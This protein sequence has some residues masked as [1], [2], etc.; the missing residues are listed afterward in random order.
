MRIMIDG[1][2]YE[3]T[4]VEPPKAKEWAVDVV[5]YGYESGAT[6]VCMD[7][8]GRLGRPKAV[9]A[10]F[11]FSEEGVCFNDAEAK[12]LAKAIREVARR[13]PTLDGIILENAATRLAG[14]P[15]K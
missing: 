4:K 12:G 14:P 6:Y 1:T 9:A 5:F 15:P 3:A 8:T 2:E 11:R 7:N 10:Q 13:L